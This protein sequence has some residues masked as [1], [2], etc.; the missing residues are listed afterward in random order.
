MRTAASDHA[1]ERR[2]EVAELFRT[3]QVDLKPEYLGLDSY[4]VG[5]TPQSFAEKRSR[6]AP[7]RPCV[8]TA[9]RSAL[10]A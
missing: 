6:P 8:A 10:H 4:P 1:T 9:D 5:A 3:R 2:A 7:G